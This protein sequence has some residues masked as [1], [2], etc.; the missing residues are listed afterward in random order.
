MIF[1]VGVGRSGTSLLQSML[2]AHS[3]IAF[4]PETQF[5]RRIILPW[6]DRSG[7]FDFIQYLQD[8]KKYKR[9]NIFPDDAPT[10]PGEFFVSICKEYLS[11]QGKQ[12]IGEKDPK[13]LE[14]VDLIH[15]KF[16]NAYFINMVRDPRDVVVSRMKANWSKRWPFLLHPLVCETQMALGLKKFEA[17]PK[18]QVI[19]IHYE[20]LLRN[21][22]GA[23]TSILRNINLKFEDT[24][25]DFQS[26]ARQLVSED[27]LQWKSETFKPLKTNNHHNWIR[28]LTPIQVAYI[29]RVCRTAFHQYG[30]ERSLQNLN[31]LERLKILAWSSMYLPFRLLYS[32]KLR[33][34]DT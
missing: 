23:L 10:A 33:L 16:P 24:M 3:Q 28:E 11:K 17:I 20:E 8:D 9:V 15:E 2:N 14:V 6:R 26:A 21:P 25:L 22:K 12:T 5:F 27:E 13:N 32:L 1:I 19:T 7:K 34:R 30:Y 29:E 18:N 31:S 4:L